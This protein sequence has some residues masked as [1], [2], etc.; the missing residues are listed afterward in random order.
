MSGSAME[1]NAVYN[2]DSS[3]GW[4]AVRR[5]MR[6]HPIVGMGK[7]VAPADPKRGSFSRYEAWQDLLMMACHAPSEW[8]N[9]G[10]KVTLG[11][12]QL[13]GA[14]SFLSDRWNW[15]VKQVRGFLERLIGDA[16]IGK[17]APDEAKC[18][19]QAPSRNSPEPFPKKGKQS[20]NLVQTITICNYRIYQVASEIAE[21]QKGQAKGKRRASEG[22]DSSNKE[23]REQDISPIGDSSPA[24][25]GDLLGA[26]PP[27]PKARAKAKPRVGKSLLP[28]DWILPA[29]WRDETKLKFGATDSQIDRQAERFKRW[30]LSPDS[31]NRLKA[32]WKSTWMNWI[33]SAQSRGQL[34]ASGT[35]GVRGNG[36]GQ[37]ARRTVIVNG[38]ELLV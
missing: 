15:T 24:V 1:N 34:G 27:K 32:D 8:L 2:P 3:N 30:W 9:K 6:F 29:E 20:C 25:Q 28:E 38:R 12:G 17:E 16:M 7:P 36:Y 4:I 13:G 31:K 14:Y 35:N 23:T 22:H 33:D 11:V 19:D 26:A 10:R 21:I 18:D 37:P 5:A